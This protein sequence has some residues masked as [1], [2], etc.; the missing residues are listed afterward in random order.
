VSVELRMTVEGHCECGIPH[1]IGYRSE[2][3]HNL[4][5]EWGVI[6]HS[7]P[8]PDRNQVGHLMLITPDYVGQ[9]LSSPQ[10][11]PPGALSSATI[12]GERLFVHMDYQGHKWTWEL[13]EAHWGDGKNRPEVFVGRWPD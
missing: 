5:C 3:R 12:D 11:H 6:E 1:D 9:L 4:V 2:C 13:F 7:A 10:A 8:R